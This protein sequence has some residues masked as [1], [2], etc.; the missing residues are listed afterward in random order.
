MVVLNGNSSGQK[1]ARSN[2]NKPDI[3]APMLWRCWS[4]WIVRMEERFKVLYFL[5][6]IYNYVMIFFCMLNQKRRF[7]E[8][9]FR[10]INQFLT[11]ISFW[12]THI[13]EKRH[14]KINTMFNPAES[15]VFLAEPLLV[16]MYVYYACAYIEIHTQKNFKIKLDSSTGPV[17]SSRDYSFGL[18]DQKGF[19]L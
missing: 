9:V 17:F 1:L 18:A 4:L 3:I 14:R 13:P 8:V 2:Y 12:L 19:Y 11:I 7:F 5:Y 6:D 16:Q 15:I 10:E